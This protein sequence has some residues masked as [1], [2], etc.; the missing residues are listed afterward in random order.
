MIDKFFTND[1]GRNRPDVARFLDVP[2]YQYSGYEG[3]ISASEVG[4]GHHILSLKIL[5]N[6][7]KGYYDTKL[8]IE[9][10]IK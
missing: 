9:L 1:Y 2:E 5:T 4:K 7:K 8:K 3:E 6:D 10:D